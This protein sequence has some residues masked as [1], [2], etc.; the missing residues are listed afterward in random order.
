MRITS[1]K[2]R[3]L[4]YL[5]KRVVNRDE[6]VNPDATG[7]LTF[8]VCLF[9][10]FTV[11]D[12]K[13]QVMGDEMQARAIVREVLAHCPQVKRCRIYD[14]KEAGQVRDDIVFVMWAGYPFLK[15]RPGKYLLWLQ[16]AGFGGR[17]PEFLKEY[18]HVFSPSKKC[19]SR[20]PEVTYLAMACEDTALFSKREPDE[21]F[22]SKVCFVGNYNDEQRPEATQRDF[23]MPAAKYDFALWGSNWERS[24]FEQIRKAARGRLEPADIPAVY[25]SSEI[26]LSNHWLV[27]R[28]EE[29]ITTRI[30]EAL[31]C[32]SFVISDYFGA[33]DELK[34][35]L[36]FTNGG[37][38]LELKLDYYLARPDKRQEKIKGA[39][40]FIL[41]NHTFANRVKTVCEKIELEFKD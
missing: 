41:K 35:H 3:K 13:L 34:E 28:E 39:R 37:K 22:K 31:S 5:V 38:D 40:E 10:R 14:I 2:I 1:K 36:E 16:N 17:M 21:R 33:L 26:V 9:N 27:H 8:G 18:G 25:S 6:F 4:Y 32:G 24:G 20:F 19:C 7:K 30:Y 23:L 11:S 15:R 12:K 29:M